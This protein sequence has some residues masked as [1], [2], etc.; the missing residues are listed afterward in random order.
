MNQSPPRSPRLTA[1][2]RILG[3][4][5]ALWLVLVGSRTLW[6]NA[7]QAT[8]LVPTFAYGVR[9]VAPQ[10]VA[11]ILSSVALVRTLP[12]VRWARPD[13]PAPTLRWPWVLVALPLAPILVVLALRDRAAQRPPPTPQTL[14]EAFHRLLLAPR[15]LALHFVGWSAAAA[16]VGVILLGTAAGWSRT[17]MVVALAL[18]LSIAI[19]LGTVLVGWARTVLRPQVL[20][21]PRPPNRFAQLRGFRLRMVVNAMLATVAI[22]G[23]PLTA[24]VLWTLHQPPRTAVDKASA[25]AQTV[26][27]LVTEGYEE[28]LGALLVRHRGLS[29]RIG[30]RQFGPAYPIE[31][32]QGP[33]DL[34]L[35]ATPDIV[36]VGDD[37]HHVTVRIEP[38]PE[39]SLRALL[40]GA[41]ATFAF[42]STAIVLTVL[43]LHRDLQQATAL[44]RTVSQGRVSPP[45]REARYTNAEVAALVGSVHRLVQRITDANVAK[46]VAIERAKEADRLKSQFL[47]NMSHDLRS[48][49]NSILGFSELLLS[50][51]DGDLDAEQREMLDTIHQNGR[52]LLHQIDDILDTAK[53]E[54]SRLDLHPE[55][56]PTLPLIH[57]AI[58]N[59]KKRQRG[60]IDYDVDAS[61][62]LPPAIVDTYRTIQA[63]ENVLLFASER[64]DEGALHIRVRTTR[65]ARGRIIVMRIRTPV[66]PATKA[67]LAGVLRG[68]HRIPGHRGLGL[69]LPLAGA[70]LE[71]Q[72]GTLDIEEVGEGMVFSAEFRA[73]EFRRIR[74]TAELTRS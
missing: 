39:T 68:F 58:H 64:M 10:V 70:I 38:V 3:G 73:P 5:C 40:V 41:M 49:L 9:L 8:T 32:R 13:E 22:V 2:I 20:S 26:S 16:I 51:I 30:D 43:A 6:L 19:A 47:A 34:D 59:A 62:G 7:V 57:R 12:R 29:V 36:A 53:I 25:L 50:G 24:A 56:T 66:R 46:Y 17:E 14:E 74:Q 11:I 18:E 23:I 1:E 67:Q 65:N 31:G 33:I 28:E 60:R 54:A 37:A 48:P 52:D 61:A 45:S 69:G 44:A 71:L 15:K 63:L 4:M 42:A 72:G 21:C 55:P 35:D 27:G